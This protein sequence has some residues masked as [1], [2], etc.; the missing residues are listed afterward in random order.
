M[1][2]ENFSIDNIASF[3]IEH[4]NTRWHFARPWWKTIILPVM[5]DV[6]CVTRTLKLGHF[7]NIVEEIMGRPF[8][9]FAHWIFWKCPNDQP[10]CKYTKKWYISTAAGNIFIKTNPAVIRFNITVKNTRIL[11]CAIGNQ[12]RFGFDEDITYVG[13]YIPIVGCYLVVNSDI[14]IYSQHGRDYNFYGI[15]KL[16]VCGRGS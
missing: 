11:L 15:P 10:S 14:F 3:F 12:K 8:I 5:K 16:N 6:F 4:K 1:L 13:V 2:L 9:S 7:R